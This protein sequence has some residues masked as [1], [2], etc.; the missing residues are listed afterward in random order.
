MQPDDA[1]EYGPLFEA[2]PYAVWEYENQIISDIVDCGCFDF[3]KVVSDEK[4]AVFE[5]SIDFNRYAVHR[6]FHQSIL[7]SYLIFLNLF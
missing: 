3:S 2:E 4:M 6:L 1:D 5:G 7:E